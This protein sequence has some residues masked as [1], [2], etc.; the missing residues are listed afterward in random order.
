VEVTMKILRPEEV[1][2][3]P[4]PREYTPEEIKEAYALARAAFTAGD[5]Q[6]YTELDECTSAEEF[7]RE[8]EEADK[9][10][11]ARPQ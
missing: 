6:K 7:L 1:T 11:D 5:L 8:L 9:E 10:A 2:S 3:W 4:E